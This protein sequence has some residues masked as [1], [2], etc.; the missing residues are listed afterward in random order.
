MK[1][2]LLLQNTPWCHDLDDDSRG[3]RRKM[4]ILCNPVN[5]VARG[6]RLILASMKMIVNLC[7]FTEITHRELSANYFYRF[8]Q[9]ILQQWSKVSTR[10]WKVTHLS[11][12]QSTKW[13]WY[14]NINRCIPNPFHTK[15]PRDCSPPCWHCYHW[16][17]QWLV[18]VSAVT[19]IHAAP[20]MSPLGGVRPCPCDCGATAVLGEVVST[21][22]SL[23][24]TMTS[25]AHH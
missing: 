9:N 5:E 16:G 19:S 7:A 24:L 18:M 11:A 3:Q 22:S 17:L 15:E 25:A 20:M 8:P 23:P 12:D 13:S 2:Q 4:R 21:V 10:V 6:Q 1:C 14:I